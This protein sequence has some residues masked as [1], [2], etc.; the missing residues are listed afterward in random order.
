VRPVFFDGNVVYNWEGGAIH[1]D[2]TA[3]F[4]VYRFHSTEH[5]APEGD[6]TNPG[7]NFGGGVEYFV[8]R[9]GAMTFELLYH[10]VDEIASPLAT[11]PHGS[12]WSFSVGGKAYFG[13]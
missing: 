6:D 10:T 1:P 3:G 11:F 13:R 12:F 7:V 4:G 8:T 2:V 9:R 5:G